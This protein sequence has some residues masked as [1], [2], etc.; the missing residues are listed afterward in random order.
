M[1]LSYKIA[2]QYGKEHRKREINNERGENESRGGAICVVHY[3]REYTV[4]I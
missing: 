4:C 2:E 1:S 3:S